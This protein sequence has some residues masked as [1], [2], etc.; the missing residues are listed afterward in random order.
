MTDSQ[1]TSR[2]TL[3]VVAVTSHRIAQW[4]ALL[5]EQPDWP[6]RFVFEDASDFATQARQARIVLGDTPEAA[7]WLPRLT[8]V[9][10]YQSTYSGV[11]PLLPL[12][13]QLSPGLVVTN[14][15][16]IAGPHIAEYV[17][18]HVLNVTR[19]ITE[20][21]EYQKDCHWHWQDY[22]SIHE[23]DVLLLGTGA[24]GQSVAMHL[25]NWFRRIDGCSA[26]GQ[27]QPGF[28]DISRWPALPQ[29]LARYRVIVN[30]L[31]RTPDT[32]DLLNANFF[33]KLADNAIF[34]NTGRGETVVDGD[35][36]QALDD[37]PGR[38]AVLDVF[39]EEPLP[40][41]HAYWRHGQ[42]TVTPHVAA[43]S[44]PEWVLPIFQDN[45]ERFLA[46][47][48]LKNKVDLYRGY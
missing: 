31:P 8:Q 30:T 16:Q 48:P 23:Q 44:R 34:I 1:N 6:V 27:A 11:D 25:H 41:D 24:I 5:N 29:P 15:R 32:D 33:E 18:G 21:H 37:Q 13:D 4:K 12:R 3:P 17:L 28:A 9:E 19:Q 10:W 40:G 7:Q 43:L 36:L 26:S 2:Q 39:R 20:F 46:G 22:Q 47:Q 38:R 42:V 35:L 45:L 14:S